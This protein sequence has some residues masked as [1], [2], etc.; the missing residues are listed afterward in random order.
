MVALVDVVASVNSAKLWFLWMRTVSSDK[1]K[2]LTGTC[3]GGP[4]CQ[5][6]SIPQGRGR[7]ATALLLPLHPCMSRL[8]VDLGS[9]PCPKQCT[10]GQEQ[11]I[12]Q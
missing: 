11:C 10:L 12:H 3:C 6:Y 4:Q 5:A 1:L 8:D 7:P 2:S 9:E